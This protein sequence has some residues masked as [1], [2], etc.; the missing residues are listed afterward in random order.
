MPSRKRPHRGPHRTRSAGPAAGL[1]R[2]DTERTRT[3]SV[4]SSRCLR[5]GQAESRALFTF[6]G[7]TL[8]PSRSPRARSRLVK[9]W[10]VA[11]SH[12]AAHTSCPALRCEKDASHRLL[13]PTLDTSTPSAARFLTALPSS[14]GAFRPRDLLDCA[15]PPETAEPSLRPSRPSTDEPSGGASL[16]G[17]PPASA[18]LQ[19]LVRCPEPRPRPFVRFEHRA[20]QGG[21][22]IEDPSRAVLPECGL[23]DRAPSMQRCL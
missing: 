2:A 4:G 13:Q 18:P 21:I 1:G 11:S 9:G 22:S 19:S 10:W 12:L 20:F 7:S 14:H 17:E 15:D 8:A 23:F 3:P 6:A 5:T 16:D